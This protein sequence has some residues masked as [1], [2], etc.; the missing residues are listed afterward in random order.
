MPLVN[1][2]ICT[3]LEYLKLYLQCEGEDMATQHFRSGHRSSE[4]ESGRHFVQYTDTSGGVLEEIAAKCGFK[5]ILMLLIRYHYLLY[6][7]A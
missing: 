7:L 5:V 3:S 2:L 6:V 1:Y 4:M